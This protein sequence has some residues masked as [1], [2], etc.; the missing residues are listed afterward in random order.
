MT[1]IPVSRDVGHHQRIQVAAGICREMFFKVVGHFADRLHAQV[2]A[3]VAGVAAGFVR[4]GPLDD[5][6]GRAVLECRDGGGETGDAGADHDDVES[7][8]WVLHG[9]VSVLL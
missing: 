1:A 2:G 9:F 4:R 5:A 7:L 6:D 3:R 8:V